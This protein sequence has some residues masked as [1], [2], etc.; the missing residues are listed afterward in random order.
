MERPILQETDLKGEEVKRDTR[1]RFVKGQSGNVFGK[2]KGTL[3]L[4][5]LLKKRLLKHPED[6][7]KIIKSLIN[8]GQTRELGAIKEILDRVDGKVVE[9][10]QIEGEMPIKL[11]FIPAVQVLSEQPL[12]EEGG[13][14]R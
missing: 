7:E 13:E 9:K 11:L 6:A 10:H 5:A 14:S 12:I 4:V 8:M 2:Q 3:S 1:G